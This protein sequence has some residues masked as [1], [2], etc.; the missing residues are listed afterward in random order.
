M[1]EDSAHARNHDFSAAAEIFA[2]C[3][4]FPNTLC[5]ILCY[6]FRVLVC[7]NM[8]WCGVE[9]EAKMFY[10]RYDADGQGDVFT[11]YKL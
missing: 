3:T 7:L 2:N 4:Y 9:G 1:R 5:I 11:S 6:W 8:L 10:F